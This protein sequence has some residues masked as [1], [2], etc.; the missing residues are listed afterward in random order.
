MVS[1]MSRRTCLGKPARALAY[2]SFCDLTPAAANC[3][4]HRRDKVSL[5]KL[6]LLQRVEPDRFEPCWRERKKQA[7]SK[8]LRD[9]RPKRRNMEQ[10][11]LGKINKQT[12]K[13]KKCS[14]VKNDTHKIRGLH[15]VKNKT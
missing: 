5:E 15:R 7:K 13:E 6:Q 4:P 14:V 8:V 12:S 10:P 3:P 9:C 11:L 1:R 2:L